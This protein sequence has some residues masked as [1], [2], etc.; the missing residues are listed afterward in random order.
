M[1]RTIKI[2]AVLLTGLISGCG[3]NNDFLTDNDITGALVSSSGGVSPFVNVD[4]S[5]ND[6]HIPQVAF[7]GTNYLVVYQQNVAVHNNDI[8]GVFVSSSG[9]VGIPF[10]INNSSSDDNAPR[11]AFDGTN[12]L[13]VYEEDATL[14]TASQPNHDIIGTFVSKT[15][16]VGTPFPIDDSLNDDLA[17]AVAFGGGNYLVV[18]EEDETLPNALTPNHDIIGKQVTTAGVVGSAI[19]I[20]TSTL[21]DLAPAVA[22]NG[23]SYL[24]VHQRTAMTMPP[25]PSIDNI[26]GAL[27]DTAGTVLAGSPFNIDVTT[28]QNVAPAVASDG[29]NY[30]VAYQ[31]NFS[32]GSNIQGAIVNP[33][34]PTVSS[35]VIDASV[36]LDDAAPSIAFNGTNYLVAYQDTVNGAE[37]NII[38]KLVNTAG[39]VGNAAIEIDNTGFD[40]V[41]PAVASG[42]TGYFVVYEDVF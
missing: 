27:V 42:G 17:P 12:Y 6:D 14:P 26:I 1:N 5:F 36:A 38:G 20:D 23:T 28:N 13:V 11:V 32:S 8:I 4:S 29:T 18:Y 33:T 16:L 2:V 35:F 19:A 31:R 41:A 22:S 7:D 9:S 34:G 24:V 39:S 15:G 37:D 40:T 30:L 10:A 21:D 25:S 3:N